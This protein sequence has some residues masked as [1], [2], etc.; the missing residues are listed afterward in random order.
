MKKADKKEPDFFRWIRAA[1]D[2]IY[3][4][5]RN[6]TPEEWVA[7][8]NARSL[9]ARKSFPKFTPEEAKRVIHDALYADEEPPPSRKA[10]A[11]TKTVASRRKA[12]KRLAH[13]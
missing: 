1:R 12:S 11:T 7:Y 6:M 4:D 10:K 3:R 2:R 9:E 13:A 8:T 5:T